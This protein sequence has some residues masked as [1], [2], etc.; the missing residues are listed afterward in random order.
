MIVSGE[1]GKKEEEQAT[2]TAFLGWMSR[3]FFLFWPSPLKNPCCSVVSVRLI[4]QRGAQIATERV[5]ISKLSS[6][7]TKE[8]ERCRSLL[9]TRSRDTYSKMK[10]GEREVVVTV[11][12]VPE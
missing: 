10:V 9:G 2:E 12:V 1:P 7:M 8:V 4:Q 3:H 5:T 11:C 6:P